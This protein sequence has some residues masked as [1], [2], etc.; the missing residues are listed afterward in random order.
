MARLTP[1]FSANRTVRQYAEE[2][3]LP[4]ARAYCDRA[5]SGGAGGSALADWK[6]RMSAR[7]QEARFEAVGVARI[8]AVYAF[9]VQVHLGTIDSGDVQVEIYAD[10]PAPTPPF[11]AG[12]TLDEASTVSPGAYVFRGTAAADRPVEEYT[13]RMIPRH[14]KALIPLELPLIT[15]SK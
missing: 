10:N 9:S 7:W 14:A 15:W 8:G 5:A 2:H 4:L 11:R 1:A 3:Y 6:R 13:P 12:M